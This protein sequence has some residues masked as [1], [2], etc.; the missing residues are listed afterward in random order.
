MRILIAEDDMVSRKF[1]SK[2][3]SNY[4]DCDVTVDGME[5][6]KAFLMAWNEGRPYDLV[7]LD[8]MMPKLD[9][10]TTLKRIRDLEKAKSVPEAGRVKI[11]MTTVLNDTDSI[12]EAFKLGCEGYAAKPIDTQKFIEVIDKMGLRNPETAN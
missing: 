3:L 9:G 4:G 2:F 12:L 1:I 10:L 11:I 5:T 6:L 7:C 8:I